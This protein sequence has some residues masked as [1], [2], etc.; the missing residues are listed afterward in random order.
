[1][2]AYRLPH[3]VEIEPVA[4]DKLAGFLHHSTPVL[5]GKQASP[6]LNDPSPDMITDTSK[7][8]V[9]RCMQRIFTQFEKRETTSACIP[10]AIIGC[11]PG[12]RSIPR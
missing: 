7:L 1:M 3:G 9:F 2:V 10:S 8:I 4:Q 11:Y 12:I 6:V 5:G